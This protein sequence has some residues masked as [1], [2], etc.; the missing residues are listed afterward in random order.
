M[1]SSAF[2][3]VRRTCLA[4]A[5]L[6]TPVVAPPNLAHAQ[7]AEN[8]AAARAL[9][10]EGIQLANAG[11]CEA[12]VEKLSRAEALYHAPTILG[13]LGECQVN[14]G[15]LVEGTE[16][17]NRVVRENLPDDAPRAFV[18]ARERAQAVLDAA[19]P[20]IAE[21]KIIVDP[22]VEGLQVR[23]GD[24]PVP[25]ALLGA[26]RPTD[27]G[28]HLVVAEAPGYRSATAEVTLT[29]GDA[30]SVSLSLIPEPESAVRQPVPPAGPSSGT[31]AQP[32]DVGVSQKPDKT[33]AYVLWGVGGAG[34]ITGSITGIL[35]M[36]E[37]GELDDQCDTHSTCPERAQHTIDS[38]KT[39]ALVS[40]IGFG[41]G[42]AGAIAGTIVYFTGSETQAALPELEV[43]GTTARP[44][45]G[46]D[47][48]GVVGQF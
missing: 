7:S 47:R 21:L 38:A 46:P 42:V 28:T 12:A 48:V 31:G 44:Y 39:M 9:G 27:P 5:V 26:D 36:N 20:K 19:L 33:L 18:K 45:L 14:L 17:L 15:K 34:L 35:A 16:N 41:V 8:K 30:Q 29:E 6:V 1:S 3:K 10:V 32:M 40:T 22:R 25:A 37:K 4:L 11:N 2:R 23:V 24:K 43:Y 13:R